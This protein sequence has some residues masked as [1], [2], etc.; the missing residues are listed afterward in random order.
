MH[1]TFSLF[2]LLVGTLSFAFGWGSTG[3]RII[4]N[5]AVVHLPASMQLFIDQQK[6]FADHASDADH[7]KG[8]DGLESYKHYI[9]IDAYPDFQHITHDY[10]SLIAEY[11][12]N[13]V[14]YDNGVLPWAT[15]W[16]YDSLTAQLHRGDFTAAYQTAADLGHYVADGHQPLHAT[17][18][19]NGYETGN[20]G[21]H[22]RYESSMVDDFQNQIAIT[23]DSVHYIDDV[24]GYVFNYIL[25]SNSLCDSIFHADNAGKAATGGSYTTQYYDTLWAHLGEMTDAQIQSATIDL[26]SLWY[27]AWVNAGLLSTPTNVYDNNTQPHTYVLM[28]NYPNPFNPS[29]TIRFSIPRE[30]HVALTVFNLKGQKVATLIND[31]YQPGTYSVQWNARDVASGTYLYRFETNSFSETKKLILLK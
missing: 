23:K 1:R 3:H 17:K 25:H 31:T 28:Q 2:L 26:A 18:N 27:T 4:N 29:T 6:F 12:Y 9:D 19:Y 7:R 22:S 14:W 16:T 11:G 5:N 21:I 24:I 15:L 10:D 20:N 30:Q 8:S 13:V